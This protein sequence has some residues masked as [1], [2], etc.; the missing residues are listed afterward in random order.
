MAITDIPKTGAQRIIAQALKSQEIYEE[1]S[2]QISTGKLHQDL[3]G[4][5]GD[6]TLERLLSAT[7]VQS[8]LDD[9]TRSNTLAISRLNTMETALDKLTSLATDASE[10]ITGARNSASGNFL[11]V[12]S[13]VESLLNEIA[14]SLNAKFNGK[15]LFSGSKTDTEPVGSDVQFSNVIDGAATSGYYQGDSQVAT[16]KASETQEVSYGVTADDDAFSDLIGSLHLLVEGYNSGDDSVLASASEMVTRATES[17]IALQGEIK[18]SINTLDSINSTH[19]DA[20]TLIQENLNDISSTCTCCRISSRVWQQRLRMTPY[21]ITSVRSLTRSSRL[22]RWRLTVLRKIQTLTARSC[23]MG[24][25]VVM[26][27]LRRLRV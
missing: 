23:L 16:V 12:D 4:Y 11:P 27:R 6:G 20:K 24:Q 25:L 2:T 26:R 7:E 22:W 18:S 10:L 14:S 3:K 1:L 21:Q 5:A 9:Y 15:Y 19:E 17:V 8:S 13:D